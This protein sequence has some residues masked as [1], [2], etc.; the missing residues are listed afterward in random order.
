MSLFRWT[1]PHFKHDQQPIALEKADKKKKLQQTDEEGTKEAQARS[2][3]RCEVHWFGKKAR[4]L[5]HCERRIAPGVHHMLSGRG[6]RG[7]GASALA[8]HK[9]A[10]CQECHDL[11]TQKVFRRVGGDVPLFTDEYEDVR[12]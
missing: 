4:K 9:Q 12:K 6:V 5:T 2:K 8:V 7:R 3:G 1:E 10:V 11:I